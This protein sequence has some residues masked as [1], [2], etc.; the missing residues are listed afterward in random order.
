[1]MIEPRGLYIQWTIPPCPRDLRAWSTAAGA[2]F[3]RFLVVGLFSRRR[4][5]GVVLRA[6][7]CWKGPIPGALIG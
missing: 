4:F 1:M 3:R 7:L 2:Y 5:L 6:L